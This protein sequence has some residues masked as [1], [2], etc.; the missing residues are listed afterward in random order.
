MLQ[1]AMLLQPGKKGS[2]AR[3]FQ[4]MEPVLGLVLLLI[5]ASSLYI[6]SGQDP[7]AE[8]RH[9]LPWSVTHTLK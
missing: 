6:E 9:P 1:A 2:A 8:E 3:I 7:K 5:Q 4:A